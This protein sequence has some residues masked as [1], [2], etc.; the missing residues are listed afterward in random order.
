MEEDYGWERWVSGFAVKDVEVINLGC[1]VQDINRHD[2]QSVWT[3][4]ALEICV[5]YGC[6]ST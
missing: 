2:E 1:L 3:C 6:S 5:V 4:L